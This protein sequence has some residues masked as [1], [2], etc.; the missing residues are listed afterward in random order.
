MG[1]SEGPGVGVTGGVTERTSSD[2]CEEGVLRRGTTRK[3]DLGSL[4]LE[5]GKEGSSETSLR[6]NRLPEGTGQRDCI[7]GT[8]GTWERL[9]LRLKRMMTDDGQY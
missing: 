5:R 8:V 4:R 9:G 3:T 2:L 7:A 1:R 6:W